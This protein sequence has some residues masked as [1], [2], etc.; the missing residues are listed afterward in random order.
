MQHAADGHRHMRRKTVKAVS[1]KCS[2]WPLE[3]IFSE[4][5]YWKC[6]SNILFSL[7]SSLKLWAQGSAKFNPIQCVLTGAGSPLC[8][9]R[10]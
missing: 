5:F 3:S 4:W 9:H 8:P 10:T 6:R 7:K 2:L 1:V